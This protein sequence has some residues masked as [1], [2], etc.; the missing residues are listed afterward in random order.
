MRNNFRTLLVTAIVLLSASLPVSFSTGC[1]TKSPQQIALN[2]TS[3]VVATV[4]TAMKV[5]ATYVVEQ[6]KLLIN[7][8]QGLSNLANKEIK[9]RQAYVTYQKASAPVVLAGIAASS[10]STNEVSAQ[11]LAAISA[12]SQ[13]LLVLIAD[14][15]K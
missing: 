6:R 13:P 8:T 15:T 11:V 1:A 3:T 9:V 14:M 10:N 2:S 7:D 4:D 5:W 12:A